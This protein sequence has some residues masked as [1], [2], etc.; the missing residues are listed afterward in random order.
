M[1]EILQDEVVPLYYARDEKLGYSPGWVEICKRAMASS[2]PRFNSRRV[3]SDYARHFYGPAAARNRAV[4]ANGYAVAQELAVWRTQVKA[5]WPG[6]ELR[7][8]GAAVKRAEFGRPMDLAVEVKLNSL[9]PQDVRVECVLSRQLCSA[10]D[11]PEREFAESRHAREGVTQIGDDTVMIAAL[12][13]EPATDAELCCYRLQLDPPWVGAMSYTI[14]AVP[15]HSEL[16]HPYEVGL[17][18]WL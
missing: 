12:E 9:R 13:P 17:M 5:A 6:V 16:S 10:I 8:V 7:S 18:K 3:V 4:S 15:Y 14:R 2:L 11:R 1:Y